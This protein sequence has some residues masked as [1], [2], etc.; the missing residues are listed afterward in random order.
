MAALDEP[1][2]Y[3]FHRVGQEKASQSE[4]NASWLSVLA[5]KALTG[6][7]LGKA[8]AAADRVRSIWAGRGTSGLKPGFSRGGKPLAELGQSPAGPTLGT[9]E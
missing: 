8:I 2:M 5:G 6:H 7:R 9:K 1:K 3:K 4:I